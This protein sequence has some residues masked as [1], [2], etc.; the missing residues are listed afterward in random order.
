MHQLGWAKSYYIYEPS[1]PFIGVNGF[2]TGFVTSYTARDYKTFAWSDD[3][4]WISGRHRM[5]FGTDGIR[6]VQFDDSKTS[7]FGAFTFNGAFSGLAL[8]DFMLGRPSAF[9][10]RNLNQFGES[11]LHVAWYFQD[12]IRVNRRL[13]VNLGLRYELPLPTTSTSSRTIFYVPG[14]QSTV[15]KNAHPGMLFPG[16]PGFGDAPYPAKKNF[17]APRSM[18]ENFRLSWRVKQN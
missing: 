12:D 15:F 11:G 1:I 13:T 6:T 5:M 8:S 9:T 17:L 4:S 2:F 10:M 3:F 7:S 16:D 18:S 14:A